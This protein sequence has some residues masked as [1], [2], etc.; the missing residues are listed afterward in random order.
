M[1]AHVQ[2][3]N[4]QVAPSL[5]TLVEDKIASGLSISAAQIWATLEAVVNDFAPRNRELLEKREDLQQKIDAWHKAQKGQAADAV[6]YKEFLVEIGYLVK[7]G[8]DLKVT[9]ANVDPEISSIAG[10]QLVVPVMNARY[11]LNAANARW[12]SLFDALYGT[13]VIDD[14]DGAAKGGA[15]NPLRGAKVIA[16]ASGFLDKAAPLATGSHGDVVEYRV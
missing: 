14:N 8:G 1:S 15:Y 16:Y 10:P 13:D 12:G 11:A 5:V 3:G 7:D 2:K 9:T 6:A 4:L